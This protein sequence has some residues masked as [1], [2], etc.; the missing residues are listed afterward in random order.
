MNIYQLT[1][2]YQDAYDKT[3]LFSS[4]QSAKEYV[5]EVWG[6]AAE[7]KIYEPTGGTNSDGSLEMRR[8]EL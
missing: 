3:I 5:K 6:A 4:I 7:Y 1:V 2:W 8:C